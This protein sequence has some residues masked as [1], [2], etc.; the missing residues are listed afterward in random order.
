MDGEL[1]GAESSEVKLHLGDC[2]E[3]SRIH[4]SV[5]QASH[6]CTA[7]KSPVPAVPGN[8]LEKV[9]NVPQWKIRAVVFR[10]PLIAGALIGLAAGVVNMV[11][12]LSDPV[13]VAM[14]YR[15]G[16]KVASVVNTLVLFPGMKIST[17]ENE[18]VE[19]SIPSGAGWIRLHSQSSLSVRRAGI[20][21]IGGLHAVEL[22]LP[23]G[24]V[25]LWFRP[26]IFPHDLRLATSQ[27]MIWLTGTWVEVHAIAGLTRVR[28]LNGFASV[29]NRA[30]GERMIVPA[31]NCAE[32]GRRTFALRK[33]VVKNPETVPSLVTGPTTGQGD[34]QEKPPGENG[35]NPDSPLWYEVE[36]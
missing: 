24:A 4:E 32:I 34:Q 31:G 30:T 10:R 7:M 21:K 33:I 2:P 20:R 25:S 18:E 6:A 19:V 17:Q 3:C 5:K 11:S 15:S 23:K 29:R 16:D 27:A 13:P 14:T 28:V 1:S 35:P 9:R 36:K 22:E 12:Y 8:L 26:G